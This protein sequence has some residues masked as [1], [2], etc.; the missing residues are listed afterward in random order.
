MDF[1][2]TEL[3]NTV[4]HQAHVIRRL[5]LALAAMTAERQHAALDEGPQSG[6]GQHQP[7]AGGGPL[8]RVGEGVDP[9]GH[10][11]LPPHGQSREA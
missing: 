3:V 6:N 8:E 9:V 2:A 7:D 4:V 11:Y 10:A 1:D 5:E